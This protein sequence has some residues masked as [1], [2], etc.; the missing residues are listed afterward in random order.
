MSPRRVEDSP[1]AVRANPRPWLLRIARSLIA[2]DTV[3][4]Y[5]SVFFIVQSMD[6]RF[7][8][9]CEAAEVFHDRMSWLR[10]DDAKNLAAMS[11]KLTTHELYDLG[12][13]SPAERRTVQRDESLAAGDI[14]QNRF[15]LSVFD[16]VDVG[17][18]HQPIEVRQRLGSQIF[19]AVRILQLNST[20][21]HDGSELMKSLRRPMMTV[22]AHEEQF[23]VGSV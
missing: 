14:I 18:Q 3:F 19:H 23:Q 7:I 20:S 1:F 4:K 8:P 10:I 22:I 2:F 5:G 12:I 11:L 13:V 16:L 9:A 6:V 17:K 21:F 15:G